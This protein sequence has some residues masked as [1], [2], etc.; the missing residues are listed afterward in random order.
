MNAVPPWAQIDTHHIARVSPRQAGTQRR[1]HKTHPFFQPAR[2]LAPEHIAGPCC[3]AAK[4][5]SARLGGA[6]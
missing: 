1:Q 5:K 3:Q 6:G 2:P 4:P